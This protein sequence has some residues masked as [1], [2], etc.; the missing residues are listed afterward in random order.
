MDQNILALFHVIQNLNEHH[1]LYASAQ[2]LSKTIDHQE[3]NDKEILVMILGWFG[4]VNEIQS[5]LCEQIYR[6][7]YAGCSKDIRRA[8]LCH[9]IERRCDIRRWYMESGQFKLC[10]TTV[11]R[12]PVADWTNQHWLVFY[13]LTHDLY[14]THADRDSLSSLIAYI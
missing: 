14:L 3:W 12:R 13:K 11:I 6:G 1:A 8:I 9:L 7:V 5:I 10:T 2:L 4:H